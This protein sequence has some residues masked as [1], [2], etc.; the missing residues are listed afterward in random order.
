MTGTGVLFVYFSVSV[1]TVYEIYQMYHVYTV[2]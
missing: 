2:T 1:T